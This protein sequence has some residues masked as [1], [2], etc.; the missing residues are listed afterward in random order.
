MELINSDNEFDYYLDEFEGRKI[1][2]RRYRATQKILIE[3][4]EL[5]KCLG[6]STMEEMLKDKPHLTDKVLDL[7]SDGNI[8]FKENFGDHNK[9]MREFQ[10]KKGL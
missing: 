10:R 9:R 2:Y 7:I 4:G 1:Q 5:P 3:A 8:F 6:Y